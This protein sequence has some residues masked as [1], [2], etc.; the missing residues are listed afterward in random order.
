MHFRTSKK[1]NNEVYLEDPIGKDKDD[2]TITLKDVIEN[3]ERAIDE[4]IDLNFKIKEMYK[5]IKGLKEREKEV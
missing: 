1:L 5:K 2:N 3:D 4:E